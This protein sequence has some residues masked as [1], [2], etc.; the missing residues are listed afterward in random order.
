MI[1][2]FTTVFHIFIVKTT[3]DEFM[4]YIPPCKDCIVRPVCLETNNGNINNPFIIT[5]K[6]STLRKY[7]EKNNSFVIIERER[8]YNE[9]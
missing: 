8:L 9:R 3:V 5:Q 2:Y 7:L 4:E 6:C 1:E